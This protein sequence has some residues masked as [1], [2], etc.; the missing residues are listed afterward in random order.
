MTLERQK[1][2]DSLPA[3]EK[4]VR[5]DIDEFKRMIKHNKKT[6]GALCSLCKVLYT[7]Q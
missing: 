4:R 3:E 2:W 6:F 7:L 5:E 1:W